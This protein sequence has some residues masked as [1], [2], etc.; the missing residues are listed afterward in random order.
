MYAHKHEDN[1]DDGIDEMVQC[2]KIT[3]CALEVPSSQ[4]KSVLR[5]QRVQKSVWG[6][7]QLLRLKE[8]VK[9]FQTPTTLEPIS[10]NGFWFKIKTAVNINPEEY[11]S[12]SRI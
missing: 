7:R 4:W 8:D 11:S 5:A 1:I 2:P 10:K 12:I 3:A 6:V 9:D